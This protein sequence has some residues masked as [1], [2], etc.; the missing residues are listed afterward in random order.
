MHAFTYTNH[1]GGRLVHTHTHTHTHTQGSL[2]GFFTS[3]EGLLEKIRAHLKEGN[4]FGVG[5]S[6]VKHHLGEKEGATKEQTVEE[7]EE[8][9]LQKRC[10]CLFVCVY[11]YVC[12]FLR[13][14]L[15]LSS[16][17]FHSLTHTHP[18]IFIHTHTHTHSHTHTHTQLP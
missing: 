10:V 2:G 16:A 15:F 12:I 4:P 17:L 13:I 1:A 6:A 5:D 9:E 11:M 14:F 8:G 3:V 7:K 18:L